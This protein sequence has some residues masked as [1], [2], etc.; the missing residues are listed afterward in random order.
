M[1]VHRIKDYINLNVLVK[2]DVLYNS[3]SCPHLHSAI[4]AVTAK[5]HAIPVPDNYLQNTMKYAPVKS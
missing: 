2:K 5:A 3:I 4:Y 1:A